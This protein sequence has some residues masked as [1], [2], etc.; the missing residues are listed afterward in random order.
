MAS[1]RAV[2]VTRDQHEAIATSFGLL[3]VG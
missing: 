3:T 2:S 1:F